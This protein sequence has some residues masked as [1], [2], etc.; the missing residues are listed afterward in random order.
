MKDISKKKFLIFLPED[1][2][3]TFDEGKIYCVKNLRKPEKENDTKLSITKDTLVTEVSDDSVVSKFQLI[4][5]A[6]FCKKMLGVGYQSFNQYHSCSACRKKLS[7]E[8][9][10]CHNCG[11]SGNNLQIQS[12]FLVKITFDGDL[13]GDS[14]EESAETLLCFKRVF[15]ESKVSSEEEWNDFFDKN[16]NMKIMIVEYNQSS[17]DK[18]VAKITFL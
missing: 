1:K 15:P 3:N 5:N 9:K 12:D 11:E 8:S 10:C 13:E 18:I 6:E 7:N 4:S 14:Q 16:I 2:K 17:R